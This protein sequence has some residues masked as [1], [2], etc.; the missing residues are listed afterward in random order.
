MLNV[1]SECESGKSELQVQLENTFKICT[2]KT[3]SKDLP[4][5]NLYMK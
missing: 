4:I 2:L 3:R 1:N 5:F